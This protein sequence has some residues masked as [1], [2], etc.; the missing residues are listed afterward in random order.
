[1]AKKEKQR[2]GSL[3]GPSN[4]AGGN[5]GA[6]EGEVSERR[7]E[8]AQPA[9]QRARV[10]VVCG[11]CKRLKL[12]CDRRTPCGACVKRDTTDKC[13]YASGASEKIDAQFVLNKHTALEQEVEVLKGILQGQQAQISSLQ[14][15]LAT[16]QGLSSSQI[17]Y[18]FLY[19]RQTGSSIMMSFDEMYGMWADQGIDFRPKTPPAAA[20]IA[21]EHE[22]RRDLVSA[23]KRNLSLFEIPPQPIQSRSSSS[24]S[25][26]SSS[27]QSAASLA[28]TSPSIGVTTSLVDTLPSEPLRSQIISSLQTTLLLHPTV[29]FTEFKLRIDGLFRWAEEQAVAKQYN[30]HFHDPG[31]RRPSL[32]LFAAVAAAFALGAQCLTSSSNSTVLSSST[33]SSASSPLTPPSSPNEKRKPRDLF[34]L[35]AQAVQLHT[36]AGFQSYDTD[37]VHALL[38]QIIY[39]LHTPANPTGP[40]RGLELPHELF[41]IIGSLVNVAKMLGLSRDPDEAPSIVDIGGV[42]GVAEGKRPMAYSP[43]VGHERRKLWWCVMFYDLCVF[44]LFPSLSFISLPL[45]LFFA[46]VVDFA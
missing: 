39:L 3:A 14:A 12:K 20:T 24:S 25:N 41:P 1:M 21:L 5:S 4:T 31:R 40:R 29:N 43:F 32:S 28:N 23:R 11:E 19:Q 36:D 8:Q 45:A 9:Q 34:V 7:S 10:T 30:A 17:S 42:S 2:A 46:F 6:G 37:I 33:S 35:S 27:R 15:Q 18:E 16:Q 44:V 38:L 26:S 22:E 13:I